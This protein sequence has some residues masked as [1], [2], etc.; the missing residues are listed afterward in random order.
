MTIKTHLKKNILLATPVVIGQIGHIMV[1]VADSVMVGRLGVIPLAGATFANSIFYVLFLFGI[2]VSNALTP[3]VSSTNPGNK[4]KLRSLLQNNIVL[5]LLLGVF[6]FLFTLLLSFFLSSFGQEEEVVSAATPY[7][8]IIGGSI[9]PVMV[10]QSFRQ[11]AEG[12][13]DTVTPMVVS[14]IGNLIN[15][16][17][18]YLLIYGKYGF[19]F[20]GL[21]GAGVASACSRLI[22]MFL[23]IYSTQKLWKGLKRSFSIKKIKQ[24]FK[25]G[26][27]LGFQYVFEVG[28][29]AT[30]AIMIGWISAKALAAHQIAISIVAVTYM[31]ASGIATAASVRVG[32]QMGLKDRKNLRLA[33]FSS[34]WLVVA[35][36]ALCGVL[37]IV[38]RD[39]LPELY[40]EDP[41]VIQM[42]SSLLI[43]GAAFQI[44]DG[45]QAVGL[46]TLRGLKDVYVPTAVTF[47]AYWLI[48]IPLAYFMA[49]HLEQ[50][51]LGIW[52]GLFIGLTAAAVLH[53]R[54][55]HLL[56]KRILFEL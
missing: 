6:I 17:L 31:S 24:Q 10:F 40:I 16:G 8:I 14:I 13:S 34:F 33:G 2:G 28:A 26:I 12:L 50:G 27:P 41:E 53:V 29:F 45:V 23:M 38:S 18:N 15:I 7:L 20:L 37:L 21:N 46:G 1:G 49:F 9:I 52:Y 30:A 55:F 11:Y 36:M 47:I 35:F 32:N 22:M 56:S 44:S 25:L 48:A 3:L 42:A 19:P 43:I 4:P 5:N 54:R 39:L 51:I